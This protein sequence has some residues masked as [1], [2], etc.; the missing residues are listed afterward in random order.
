MKG[1]VHRSRN[2]VKQV[3]K[4]AGHAAARTTLPALL[5]ALIV[6]APGRAGAD[7]LLRQNW[8]REERD[9]F[10]GVLYRIAQSVERVEGRLQVADD[11]GREFEMDYS[12]GLSFPGIEKQWQPRIPNTRE[13][14]F[15]LTEAETL[16]D[17][18]NRLEAVLVW[19]GLVGM[20]LY[21]QSESPAHVRQT[22]AAASRVLDRLRTQPGFLPTDKITDPF[23]F[24]VAGEETVLWSD[25][26]SVRIVMRGEFRF[27]VPQ[28]VPTDRDIERRIVFLGGKGVML[29]IGLENRLRG[30]SVPVRDYVEMMDRRRGAGEQRITE[31]GLRRKVIPD[32]NRGADSIVFETS[33]TTPSAVFYEYYAV[34]ETGGLWIEARGPEARSTLESILSHPKFRTG[35]TK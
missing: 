25:L 1:Y 8:I 22:A 3:L 35:G 28:S 14:P 16:Y 33:T 21:L 27:R 24:S 18:G 30:R 19:K 10:Q 11:T 20:R 15:H 5:T 13:T 6:I 34:H 32:P 12:G 2:I 7:P 23:V 31:I 4:S 26:F 9:R 29:T 17:M